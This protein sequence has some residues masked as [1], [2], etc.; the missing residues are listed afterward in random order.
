MLFLPAEQLHSRSAATE[1]SAPRSLPVVSSVFKTLPLGGSTTPSRICSLKSSLHLSG[2]FPP[3]TKWTTFYLALEGHEKQSLTILFLRTI[4]TFKLPVGFLFSIQNQP[5]LS[6]LRFVPQH[7][8]LSL[9]RG[10]LA[11]NRWCPQRAQSISA[12]R[13]RGRG[14]TSGSSRTCCNTSGSDQ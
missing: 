10:A 14:N 13:A 5:L 6:S 12:G 9:T 1:A 2:F 11:L 8:L 7:T 3:R 4:S